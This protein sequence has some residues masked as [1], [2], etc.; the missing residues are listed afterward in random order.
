MTGERLFLDTFFVQALLNP[1]DPSHARA[2]ALLPRVE[3]AAGIVVTEAVL[4]EIA[5][6]VSRDFALRGAVAELIASY[7]D[8]PD[9][10]VVPVDTALVRD[11]LAL[12][13]S[14]GDK[15]WGLTDCVSFVV[16]RRLGV[17]AALTADRHFV[18]AGFEAL[19]ASE[20]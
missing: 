4:L 8:R 15:T 17:R 13:V 18:Q 5:N 16:M 9:C 10:T 3:G 2:L 12:Y 1:R 11:A 6:A 20:S 7:Y 19:M 14:H